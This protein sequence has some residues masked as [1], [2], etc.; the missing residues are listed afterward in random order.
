MLR[1]AV[2]LTDAGG[3]LTTARYDGQRSRSIDDGCRRRFWSQRCQA[4]L[5]PGGHARTAMNHTFTPRWVPLSSRLPYTCL[6][7]KTCRNTAPLERSTYASFHF[8]LI[9]AHCFK[10]EQFMFVA[11]FDFI[12]AVIIFF[13][14]RRNWKYLFTKR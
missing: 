12:R 6:E 8:H 1:H 10:M 13:S 5:H 14:V 4:P 7:M 2:C 9:V 11:G 3:R